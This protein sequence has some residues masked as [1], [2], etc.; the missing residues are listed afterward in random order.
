MPE[1]PPMPLP[2]HT[3][4]WRRV[5]TSLERGQLAHALLIHAEGG[6]H[7]LAFGR[8]LAQ[9]LLCADPRAGQPCA[10][11]RQCVLFVAGNHP[12]FVEVHPEESAVVKIDQV[13]ELSARLAMRPQVAQ[14][15]VALLWPA[16]AMNVAAANAL[17][18]TLEEPAADT[19]LLLLAERVGR[20]PATIRSR[21]QR[22]PLARAEGV[23]VVAQVA[24]L[25]AVDDARAQA[26]LVYSGGDPELALGVLEAAQ[27]TAL[28][29]LLGKLGDLARGRLDAVAFHAAYRNEGPQLL[30]RWSRLIALVMR[31]EVVAD[32]PFA[33]FVG[34]TSR[35]EMSTLLPLATQ[36]ERARALVG[37]GV[38]EDLLILDLAARW[39]AAFQSGERGRVA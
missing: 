13:R 11:C 30:Q 15:Q 21:C 5:A 26:A 25:A 34:L 6:M 29:G 10:E 17:L 23:E 31:A 36:L 12:D 28:L 27:W 14:R 20:L 39:S 1:P 33:A 18:K 16:E 37:S 35:F 22:L 19:H 24:R 38:R 32:G 8:A 7:K 3:A 4:A 9:G 2:W